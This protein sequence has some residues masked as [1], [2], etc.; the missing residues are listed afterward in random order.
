MYQSS[1]SLSSSSS[2]SQG[3]LLHSFKSLRGVGVKIVKKDNIL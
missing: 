3:C 1:S 2:A